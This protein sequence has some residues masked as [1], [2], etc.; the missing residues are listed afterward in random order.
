MLASVY[1]VIFS[2]ICYLKLYFVIMDLTYHKIYENITSM[3][4]QKEISKLLKCSQPTV[5]LILN[6]KRAVSWPLA[7]R[8]TELFPDHT[9]QQWKKATPEDIERAFSQ[10]K[11]NSDASIFFPLKNHNHVWSK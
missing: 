9:I 11:I 3:I 2:A 6:G 7:E 8:L 4:T 1:F 10:L 5:N